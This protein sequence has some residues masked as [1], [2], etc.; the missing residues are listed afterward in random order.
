MPAIHGRWTPQSAVRLIE[1]IPEHWGQGT[2]VDLL[3][4][5]LAAD[6]RFR[7]WSA[8]LERLGASPGAAMALR[9]MNGQI[10]IRDTLPVIRVPTLVLHRTG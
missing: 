2:S 9:R 3:A 1:A 8:W 5:S 6:E 7:R 10:D 4:P